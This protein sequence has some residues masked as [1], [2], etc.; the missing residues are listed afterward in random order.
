MSN[1]LVE[2]GNTALKAAWSEGMTLGK[3]FRYQG[4]KMFGFIDSL[5]S[6]EKPSV[7][8]VSSTIDISPADDKYLQNKCGKLVLLDRNHTKTAIS[9]GIPEYVS[10]D[11]VAS[12]IA[13]RYLFKGTG[14]VIFDFGTTLSVDLL[15]ADGAYEGGNISLGC[16]TRFKALNRY[17]RTLPLVDTPPTVNTTGDS[18]ISSIESGVIGGIMFEIQGYLS[19]F[20]EKTPVFTGGDALYFAKRM[21]NSIFVVCNLVLMGLAII[22][23]NYAERND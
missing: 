11:R 17:S 9:N 22:A 4:E 1:L 8:V 6:K 18:L 12:V 10:P 14:S 20:P 16:R 5:V 23:D 19:Q 21:K 2:I 15:S 7:M 3:T 13:A